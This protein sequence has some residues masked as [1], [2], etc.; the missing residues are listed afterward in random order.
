V[1]VRTKKSGTYREV[2]G[3]RKTSKDPAPLAV[4]EVRVQDR[5]YVICHNED[6]A[7]KD[8]ADREAML[9][10]LET[11]LRQSATS[12]VGNKGYRKFLRRGREAASNSI[13]RRSKRTPASTASGFCK[14][15]PNWRP[16]IVR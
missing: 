1:F 8:R 4:K 6:Q 16:P 2:F 11:R 3:P 9:A 5:R 7:R 15:T 12:L 13:R 10:G 14:R